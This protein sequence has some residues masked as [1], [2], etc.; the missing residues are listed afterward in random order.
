V[1]AL[2]AN[3]I[4]PGL[5]GISNQVLGPVPPG[6][7]ALGA[8]NGVNF[9]SIPGA[10]YFTIDITTPATGSSWGRVKALYR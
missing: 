9:G 1:C 10:Q 4:G 8:A 6:T 7:C 5:G 2:L 3:L